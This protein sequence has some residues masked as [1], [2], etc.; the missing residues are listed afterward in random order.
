MESFSIWHFL[1]IPFYFSLAPLYVLFTYYASIVAFKYEF[2]H[3][4]A[5]LWLN[6]FTGP[7]GAI[8]L[9]IWVNYGLRS[10]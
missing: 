5:V 6:I 8:P 7:V 4:W 9:A 3:K 10:K 1:L 2:K